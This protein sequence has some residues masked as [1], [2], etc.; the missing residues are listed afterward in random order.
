[1][2]TRTTR[3]PAK[4]PAHRSL[5]GAKKG[6]TNALRHGTRAAVVQRGLSVLHQRPLLADLFAALGAVAAGDKD[7][8]RLHIARAGLLLHV[9]GACRRCNETSVVF[10][11]QE[12]PA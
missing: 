12:A 2:P 10:T 11:K 7:R 1:M 5:G 3:R 4:R 9:V 8:A 6:N